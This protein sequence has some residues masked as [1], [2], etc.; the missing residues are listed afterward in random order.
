MNKSAFL[1]WYIAQY[2][3]RPTYYKRMSP[4]KL[5][6]LAMAG[7]EAQSVLDKQADWDHRQD[8]CLK[9]WQVERKDSAK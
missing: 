7:K 9:A 5:F 1:D 4:D 3:P 8:A 2:G 6:A